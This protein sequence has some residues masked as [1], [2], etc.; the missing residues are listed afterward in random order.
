MFGEIGAWLFKG[1]GGIFPDENAP[2]FKNTLLRPHFIEQLDYFNSSHIGPYGKIVS[3][4][5][6]N[7]N[8]IHYNVVIPPNS[9][10]TI[11]INAKTVILNNKKIKPLN[12]NSFEIK[13]RPGTHNLKIFKN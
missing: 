4:W 6:K 12:N 2:G 13:I 11:F 8:S 9:T 1:I 3:N 10:A 7:K 5:K